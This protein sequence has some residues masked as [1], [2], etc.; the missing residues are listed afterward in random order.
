MLVSFLV[1][2]NNLNAWDFKLNDFQRAY[3]EKHNK[4]LL[5]VYQSSK[6]KNRKE[7]A[8]FLLTSSDVP[9]S[10]QN[11]YVQSMDKLKK[12]NIK[13]GIYLKGLNKKTF[14]FIRKSIQGFTK[15]DNSNNN[16]FGIDPDIF[17]K[18]QLKTVPVLLFSLCKKGA[19]EYMKQ[20]IA[21]AG[22]LALSQ[23]MGKMASDIAGTEIYKSPEQYA[24]AQAHKAGAM[25]I[26]DKTRY[27][28][29]L[30]QEQTNKK[31]NS[32]IE[33]APDSELAEKQLI[34]DGAVALD[35]NGN[36]IR[37]KD[38]GLKADL[39]VCNSRIIP[40]FWALHRF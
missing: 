14:L 18:L 10:A 36:P 21:G 6:D 30:S 33:N 31:L 12:Y 40:C 1:L 13:R 16:S 35:K 11:D 39:P 2:N 27:E 3:L 32:I 5:D 25:A 24:E 29:S 4:K 23:S 8:I 9:T 7:F 28:K 19:A 17:E 38:G 37:T 20:A 34:K 26:V 22:V 15:N